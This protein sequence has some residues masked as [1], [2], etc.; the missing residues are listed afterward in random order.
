MSLQLKNKNI[1][2]INKNNLNNNVKINLNRL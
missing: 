1:K 2:L